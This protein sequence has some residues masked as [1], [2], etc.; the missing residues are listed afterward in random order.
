MSIVKDRQLGLGEKSISTEFLYIKQNIMTW[1]NT[2]IQLSNVSFV[3][4]DKREPLK[5]PMAALGLFLLGFVFF[6][7]SVGLALI[8]LAIGGVWGYLW[9]SENQ[10]RAEGAVLTI[11]MNSGHTLYFDFETK[12]FLNTVVDVLEHIIIDGC[13]GAQNIEISIKNSKISGNASVLSNLNV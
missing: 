5:L 13:T 2:I 7:Y 4:A 12:E 9:Y 1:D 6:K 8:L 10:R 11:R 3:S